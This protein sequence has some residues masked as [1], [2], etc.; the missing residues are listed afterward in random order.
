MDRARSAAAACFLTVLGGCL[1]LVLSG[2]AGLL[3]RDPSVRLSRYTPGPEGASY[4]GAAEW[5]TDTCRTLSTAG[6]PGR[7]ALKEANAAV[8]RLAGKWIFEGTEVVRLNNGHLSSAGRLYYSEN[9]PDKQV[10]AFRDFIED[11]LGVPYLYIQ[12]PC[13]ICRLN[14]QLPTANMSS[15]NE[16]TDALLERLEGEGVPVLDLRRSLH[17][18]G[19]SHYGSFFRTDHHWTVP[20]GLWAARTVAEE[21]NVRYGL[22]LDADALAEENFSNR[23]WEGVFLGSW[24]RKVTAVFAQ[25]EDFV[26]PVPNRSVHMALYRDGAVYEGGFEALYDEGQITPENYYTGNSYGALLHGDCGYIRVENLDNPEGPVVAVLRESFAGAVG[27]YLSMA[28]GELHLIDA[29]YYGGSTRELLREIG[30]DAVV[31]LLNVQC[32]VNAYFDLVT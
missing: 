2:A 24:G 32:F 16:E 29:R 25:P 28:A 3:P 15:E 1:L 18:E 9:P 17:A 20:T 19:L 13:K 14:P 30:P 26:L 6:L 12:A 4:L 27:P 22:G 7:V 21:L 31:S 11:E 8:N 23:V 10:M 5:F